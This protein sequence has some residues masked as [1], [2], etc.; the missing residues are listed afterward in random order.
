[1]VSCLKLIP[2]K[3]FS[4]SFKDLKPFFFSYKT[5]CKQY[6]QTQRWKHKNPEEDFKNILPLASIS[7]VNSQ[8]FIG[9][10][11]SNIIFSPWAF[12]F[13]FGKGT[14]SGGIT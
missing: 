9:S 2:F 7:L 12:A 6:W 14:N 8:C 3:S 4:F 13:N 10:S 1:M 5:L 11:L